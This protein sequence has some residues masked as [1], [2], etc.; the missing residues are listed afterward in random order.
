MKICE[1]M[2]LDF[3]RSG[4]RQRVYA[5]QG[6]SYARC[7]EIAMH[8]NG[9][10][11][12]LP[13]GASAFLRY[14]KPDGT[15]GMYDTLPDG[16]QAWSAQGNRVCFILAPQMLSVPGIVQVQLEIVSGAS[17]LASFAFLVEVEPDP[18]LG[19]IPSEDYISWNAW[20]MQA[21]ENLFTVG[22]TQPDAVPALWFD[23]T[24]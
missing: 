17:N 14:R 21:L 10:A 8:E 19:V 16:T 23:T 13:T 15:G 18:S 6:D 1:K 2:A 4:I 22:D 3:A 5:V 11:W 20:A 12:E 9:A 7:L 24:P